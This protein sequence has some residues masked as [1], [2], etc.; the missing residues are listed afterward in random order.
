MADPASVA[1]KIRKKFKKRDS[2]SKKLEKEVDEDVEIRAYRYLNPDNWFSTLDPLGELFVFGENVVTIGLLEIKK[3]E[4][5]S[6]MKWNMFVRALEKTDEYFQELESEDAREHL[7]LN[8]WY[9][10]V[11]RAIVVETQRQQLLGAEKLCLREMYRKL[12]AEF[13]ELGYKISQQNLPSISG[14]FS[15]IQQ[16]ETP[17]NTFFSDVTQAGKSN[18]IIH[19]SQKLDFSNTASDTVA[20][21]VST[22]SPEKAVSAL[23]STT[24]QPDHDAGASS[25]SY[26][27]PTLPVT[28][29]PGLQNKKDANLVLAN[30]FGKIP[31]FDEY[32]NTKLMETTGW[33][34]EMIRNWFKKTRHEKLENLFFEHPFADELKARKVGVIMPDSISISETL[35]FLRNNF[36]IRYLRGGNVLDMP[37]KMQ[38]IEHC[39]LENAEPSVRNVARISSKLKVKRREVH[40]YISMREK[41]IGIHGNVHFVTARNSTDKEEK[42]VECE[43]K[44]KILP[45]AKPFTNA[46]ERLSTEKQSIEPAETETFQDKIMKQLFIN[47]PFMESAPIINSYMKLAR[48]TCIAKYLRGILT[49]DDLPQQ[50]MFLEFLLEK[51]S[52]VSKQLVVNL[53]GIAKLEESQVY[54]YI[55]M[56]S[57]VINEFNAEQRMR[58][59]AD[60]AVDKRDEVIVGGN[61]ELLTDITCLTKDNI[62]PSV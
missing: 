39:L 5:C 52:R 59:E 19:E 58:T 36:L 41:L 49:L 62:A 31:K 14:L 32:N 34:E 26:C 8:I 48:K 61:S 45:E 24:L 47:N 28:D 55:E 12:K 33:T 53:A 6:Q 30:L 20:E 9:R 17:Q 10:A 42:S 16:G 57:R 29:Q 44:E 38:I 35:K 46:G 27:P 18:E 51:S 21:T 60:K 2:D 40:S 37:K 1:Q 23:S 4:S 25:Q 50:I 43:K 7:R 22:L 56:R 54:D 11:T 15:P 13:L 3:P